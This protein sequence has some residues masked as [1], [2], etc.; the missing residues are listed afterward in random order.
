MNST[1]TKLEAAYQLHFY[2]YFQAYRSRALFAEEPVRRALTDVV[3][4]VCQREDY[5]LLEACP[6]IDHLR[7]LIS[8][9]PH[10][11]VS[12]TVKM[13]KGN[14]SR[15]LGLRF[16]ETKPW[17][18]K[19]YFARSSGKVDIETARS[20]V[21]SQATH[22]GYK[23]KWTEAL[24]LR[25]S[26]FKSP[27]FQLD[28][29]ICILSYHVVLVTKGRASVFDETIAG[30]LFNCAVAVGYKHG[31][32]LERMSILPDHVHLILEAVPSKSIDELVLAL[33]NNTAYWMGKH[34][35][36]VLKQTSAW[37]VWQPSY[38]AGTVGEYTTAQVKRFLREAVG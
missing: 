38:Y 10:Q 13:L 26:S 31:F 32:A 16:P 21:E 12:R 17:L 18:G 14:L 36:G 19:G 15:Q 25:N 8:L 22:H 33:V 5:H 7:L 11:A 29:S 35:W 4:E 24:E 9:K 23:G 1:F 20:Y 37:D 34:Y 30:G 27:A 28:H 6:S 3:D 2:L